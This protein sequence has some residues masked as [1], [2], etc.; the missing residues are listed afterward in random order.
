MDFLPQESLK[1]QE[2]V[3]KNY[4]VWVIS[5]YLLG[6]KI[7]NNSNGEQNAFLKLEE[8]HKNATFTEYKLPLYCILLVVSGVAN[9]WTNYRRFSLSHHRQNYS[10]K[11]KN[12]GDIRFCMETLCLC[13]SGGHKYGYRKLTKTCHLVLL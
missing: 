2:M 3:L 12:E 1:E 11:V 8:V 13:P 6:S 10:R 4:G 5:G 9:I 7:F